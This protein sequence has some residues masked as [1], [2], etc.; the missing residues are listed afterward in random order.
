M[1]PTKYFGT[2]GIRGEAGS[3]LSSSFALRFGSIFARYILENNASSD[4]IILG[5]DPRLS[6]DMLFNAV[7]AGILETGL[8]VINLGIV[9]TPM[10]AFTC[11]MLKLPGIMITASHNPLPDNGIKVFCNDG[12]KLSRIEEEKIDFNLQTQNEFSPLNLP[13]MGKMI[14]KGDISEDYSEFVHTQVPYRN[15]CRKLHIVIDCAHGATCTHAAKVLAPYANLLLINDNPDGKLI[16]VKCGATCLNPVIEIMKKGSFDLGI[17]FDGDGDRVLFI[18]HDGSEIN[19][20]KIIALLALYD[21][22]Y[23]KTQSAVM[24]QMTNMGTEDFL[25]DNGIKLHRTEVGDINVLNA[26]IENNIDLGGEQSG[27]IIL[28]NHITTGDGILVAAKVINLLSTQNIDLNKHLSMITDYPSRLTNLRLKDKSKWIEDK[29][30]QSLFKDLKTV[31]SENVRI[32]IR[33]SGTEPVLRILTE[34]SDSALNEKAH[35]E[36]CS[37][38]TK[39]YG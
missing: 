36:L 7:S 2:D 23:K 1:S 22:H 27:H 29:D 3:K 25:N 11:R 10:L 18:N 20:D 39:Y 34:S 13:Y 37:L 6:S 15:Q 30:F 35:S 17:S 33:P 5:R 21:D 8:N 12:F 26:M 31:Y 4:S 16:N 9:A 24:T 14:D 32:Y 38:F 28:K 19:G